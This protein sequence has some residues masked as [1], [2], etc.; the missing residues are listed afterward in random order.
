MRRRLWALVPALTF[1]TVAACSH[2]HSGTVS[3][4]EYPPVRVEVTNNHGLPVEI[5][6]VGSGITQRLGMVNP[7]MSE[8]FNLPRGMIGSG[9]V[10]LQARLTYSPTMFRS[11]PLLISPGAI[12]DFIVTAQLFNSTATLRP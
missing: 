1:L 5:Y 10:E 9:S 8:H 11:G 4:I 2:G 7:G 6:A 3:P 12:V